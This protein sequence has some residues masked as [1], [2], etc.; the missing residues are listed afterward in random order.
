MPGMETK[1]MADTRPVGKVRGSKVL[2][3]DDE[4]YVREILR[5]MLERMGFEVVEASNGD[6]G[7]AAFGSDHGDIVAC[8]IDLTMSGMSGLELLGHV[9]E[10][11]STVPVILV[12]GYSRPEVRQQEAKSRNIS[13]LQKPFTLVQFKNILERQLALQLPQ[14]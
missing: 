6:Q 14:S 4:I 3:V 1:A 2:I 5:E 8:V 11:D 13:F 9:R 12:S 10:L 7:L